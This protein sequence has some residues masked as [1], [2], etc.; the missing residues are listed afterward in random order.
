MHKFGEYLKYK[1]SS[2]RGLSNGKNK[3][4]WRL[5]SGS[6]QPAGHCSFYCV[7]TKGTTPKLQKHGYEKLQEEKLVFKEC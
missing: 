7:Y 5:G 6:V 1:K 3:K 2:N 4:G